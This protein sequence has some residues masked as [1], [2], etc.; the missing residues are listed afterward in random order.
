MRISESKSKNSTSLYIIKS[1]Y[2][3]K[4]RSSKIVEKLGTAAQIAEEHPG[5]DPYEW[6]KARLAKLNAAEDS[7]KQDVLVRY[8]T[9]KTLPKGEDRLFDGGYLF[10]QRCYTDLGLSGICGT[11]ASRHKF[12][13]D[14][15]AILSRLVFARILEPASKASAHEYSKTLLEPPPQDQQH[16]YRA[17]DV[18]AKESDFIQ[19]ELYKASKKLCKRNDKVLY[20]DCTNYYFEIEQQDGIRQYGHS[21]ENR[22]NPIVEMGLFMDA[23]G[24]PLAFCIHPGNTNEQVTL[25]PLEEQIIKDFAH[26]KFVVCTDAGLSSSANRRFNS[27]EGRSFITTQSI[28]TLK[29]HLKAWALDPTG[30]KATQGGRA[31]DITALDEERHKDTVFYK[32]RWINDGGL[33]QRL[34][35]TFSV[36]YKDYQRSIRLNQVQRAQKLIDSSPK[37]IGKARQNDFKRLIKARAVTA[38]GEIAEGRAYTLDEGKIAAEE[39][40]DGFYGVCTNLEDSAHTIAEVNHRRWEIEECFRIMKHEFKARPV[41]LRNDA[42]IEAH[43]MT[44]FIALIVYR[45]T[46]RRLNEKYTCSQIIDTLKSMKFLK[47]KGEGYLPAYTRT[48]L[49]DDL[50]EAFGFRTDYQLVTNGRMKKIIRATKK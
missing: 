19:S 17:L 38:D 34:I 28:K 29:K 5:I 3:G 13:Y 41:Y 27:I 14:L 31:Y 8:S 45:M 6:A 9:Q 46:E 30:W 48:D 25:R 36:K 11:I 50:H 15:D 24:M 21:K 23:D 49:T 26:S 4:K 16:V 40:Y 7:E 18:I 20:Y 22:P 10:L 37:S 39:A 44:C 2:D 12:T 42:R 43:F 33:E 35:V 47:V 32:E 1:T